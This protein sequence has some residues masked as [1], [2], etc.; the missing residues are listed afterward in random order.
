ML[1]NSNPKNVNKDDNFFENIYKGYVINE[2]SAKRMINSNAK[3]RGEISEL[4]ITNYKEQL[5]MK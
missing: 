2:V 1:S 3:G 4:L 5:D